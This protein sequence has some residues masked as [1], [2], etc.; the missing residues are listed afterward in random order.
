M[1]PYLQRTG[2]AVA[3]SL[4]LVPQVAR[5]FVN[6]REAE[7]LRGGAGGIRGFFELLLPVTLTTLEDSLGL[8][9]AM[10]ARGYGSGP[11]SSFAGTSW[12]YRDWLIAAAAGAALAIFVL[13]LFAGL[14]PSWDPSV[15]LSPPAVSPVALLACL[16]L[17]VPALL[18]SA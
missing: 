17:A 1:P 6:V 18:T 11:R 5:S 10:E 14:N 15:R 13:S 2:I 3:A 9:E 4:N 8:A 16:L 12:A 7:R